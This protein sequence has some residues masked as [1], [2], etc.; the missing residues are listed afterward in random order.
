MSRKRIIN[1]KQEKNEKIENLLRRTAN[2]ET[3]NNILNTTTPTQEKPDE[4]SAKTGTTKI[5]NDVASPLQ[6]PT[7]KTKRQHHHAP[8]PVT[9]H[10][11][12]KHNTEKTKLT[13]KQQSTTTTRKPPRPPAKKPRN[14]NL[15]TK[16]TKRKKNK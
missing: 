7:P 13:K 3:N 2:K 14:N 11:Q 4:K 5:T 8:L 1:S 16:G 10:K 6:N 15:Q 9:K 12:P